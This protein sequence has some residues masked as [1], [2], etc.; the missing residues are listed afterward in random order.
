[1]MSNEDDYLDHKA[2]RH[3][4]MPHPVRKETEHTLLPW[5]VG[6]QSILSESGHLVTTVVFD[7]GADYRDLAFIIR[8][9]NAHHALVEAL[10][11][12]RCWVVPTIEK[13][14]LKQIDAAL[15]LARG[16]A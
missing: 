13:A 10:K 11:E 7:E 5:E 4:S 15:K 3:Q 9:A 16:E 2:E 8:A 12:A 6:S 1:M 14:A